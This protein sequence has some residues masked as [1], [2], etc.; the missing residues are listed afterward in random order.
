MMGENLI[1]IVVST[2][3]HYLAPE[4]HDGGRAFQEMMRMADG[5]I[6]D[7]SQKLLETFTK[8]LLKLHPDA[9]LLT[10]DLTF[11]GEKT[12][13]QQIAEQLHRLKQAG[14]PVLVIPGNHDLENPLAGRY[15][16]D[17]GEP[18]EAVTKPEYQEIYGD[19]MIPDSRQQ[20]REP[21]V[22]V[23]SRYPSS[24]GYVCAISDWLWVLAVDVNG[25]T[26]PGE[27]SR[28]ILAWAEGQLRRAKEQNITVIGIS[29][30]NLFSHNSLFASSYQ[31]MGAMHLKELYQKYGVKLHLSGHTHVQ[32]NGTEDGVTEIVTAALSLGKCQYGVLNVDPA[33]RTADYHTE[34]LET[35][36]K[37]ASELFLSICK[38]KNRMEMSEMHLDDRTADRLA[39]DLA[40]LNL[41]YFEGR[42]DLLKDRDEIRAEWKKEAPESFW[43]DYIGSILDEE[44]RDQTVCRVTLATPLKNRIEG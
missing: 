24:M 39:G 2:D 19:L 13:H 37:D 38:E 21:A 3:L 22:R 42:V 17:E 34:M 14:I 28:G 18:A 40:R 44:I 15:L 33:T 29:H 10:G 1:R 27:V 12:S 5:R 7:Q 16:G 43:N 9:L 41:A 32:H 11:N 23:I 20:N 4:L 25:N 6:T 30:Q 8:R 26:Y 31:M 35:F 36:T